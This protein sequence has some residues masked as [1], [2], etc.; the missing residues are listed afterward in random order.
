MTSDHKIRHDS[1]AD[2]G[3]LSAMVELVPTHRRI[4]FASA[5]VGNDL[6]RGPWWLRYMTSAV[7]A[8]RG[9]TKT[10]TWFVLLERLGRDYADDIIASFSS[11][12][13]NGK[14]HSDRRSVGGLNQREI[15]ITL[16]LLR[17][18][19]AG[20]ELHS[21]YQ[22]ILFPGPVETPEVANHG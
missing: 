12:V 6:M 8:V 19:L 10:T 5:L 1:L 20:V 3:I 17:N 4:L 7:R 2:V 18:L 15:E 16:M 22:S 14:D 21:L 13:V 9:W 11:H